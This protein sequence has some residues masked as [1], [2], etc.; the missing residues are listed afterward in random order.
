MI[1][2]QLGF[3]EMAG[4][5]APAPGP[6]VALHVDPA[7][8][9]IDSAEPHAIGLA[10]EH[11]AARQRSTRSCRSA[12]RSFQAAAFGASTRG[13][14]QSAGDALANSLARSKNHESAM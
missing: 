3:D 1:V 14:H 4:A 7:E 2:T 13:Q 8:P 6:A 12:T 9:A 10:A 5:R 11:V